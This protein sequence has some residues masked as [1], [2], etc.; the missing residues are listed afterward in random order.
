MG[1]FNQTIE[2][3]S[4]QKSIDS[5]QFSIKIEEKPEKKMFLFDV[6]QEEIISIEKRELS[7]F[8][9]IYPF[10]NFHPNFKLN[11][12]LKKLFFFSSYFLFSFSA[13]NQIGFF[14]CLLF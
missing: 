6:I 13:Q 5:T 1:K 4:D 8:L 2:N 10:K 14:A 7:I 12:E 3:F 9:P 11:K